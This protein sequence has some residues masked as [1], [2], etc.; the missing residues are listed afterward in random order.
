[1]NINDFLTKTSDT[2]DTVGTCNLQLSFFDLKESENVEIYP[3]GSVITVCEK[4][5]EKASIEN[6]VCDIYYLGELNGKEGKIIS[7]WVDK[8]DSRIYEVVF[9]KK[10]HN[11]ILLH[12]EIKLISNN[13][14]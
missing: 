1:M 9:R 2:I 6:D 10:V 14:N 5:L 3:V 7:T 11:A 8:S 4:A 12:E 13:G